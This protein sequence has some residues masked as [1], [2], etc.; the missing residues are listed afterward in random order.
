MT[1]GIATMDEITNDELKNESSN[2]LM[3]VGQ[4]ERMACGALGAVALFRALRSRSIVGGA[5]GGALLKRA[6][7]GNCPMYSKLGINT[8]EK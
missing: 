7:S 2:D 6:I 1:E 3:N 5:F 8:A 4:L